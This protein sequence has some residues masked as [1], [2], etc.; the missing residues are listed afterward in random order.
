MQR[1]HGDMN[2]LLLLR[3]LNPHMSNFMLFLIIQ[4]HGQHDRRIFVA[5]HGFRVEFRFYVEVAV[6]S[7]CQFQIRRRPCAG[8]GRLYRHTIRRRFEL[9]VAVDGLRKI[10]Q[11]VNWIFDRCI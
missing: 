6:D 9:R 1:R 4:M 7:E 3:C 10:L 5:L 8:C 2:L 11:G